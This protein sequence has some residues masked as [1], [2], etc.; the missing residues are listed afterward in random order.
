MSNK[1]GLLGS[2]NH[3]QKGHRM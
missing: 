3:G 2:I 1:V